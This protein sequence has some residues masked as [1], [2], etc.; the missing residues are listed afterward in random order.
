MSADYKVGDRVRI[1]KRTM[2]ESDYRFNFVKEMAALEGNI[3]KISR[4]GSP[5]SSSYPVPDDGYCYSLEDS[6]GF[7][8]ASSMF[9]LVEE[10]PPPSKEEPKVLDF[11]RKKKHYQLNFS[12]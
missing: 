9:E 2:G 3:Y 5:S 6:G 7:N 10:T 12:V 8:W 4:V 1:V 11:T